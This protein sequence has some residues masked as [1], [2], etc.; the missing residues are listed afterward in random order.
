MEEMVGFRISSP[1][2]FLGWWIKLCIAFRNAGMG[3]GLHGLQVQI[4]M[5]GTQLQL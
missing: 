4:G 2:I 5:R 3:N 1:V